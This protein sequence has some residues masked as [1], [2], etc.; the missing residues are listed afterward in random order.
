MNRSLEDKNKETQSAE[1]GGLQQR[2]QKRRWLQDSI[3][4]HP[5]LSF[6]LGAPPNPA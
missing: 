1:Y 4:F 3:P 5:W 2:R 6:T